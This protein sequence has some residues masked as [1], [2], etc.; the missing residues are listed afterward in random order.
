M[1]S[2]S[3][4]DGQIKGLDQQTLAKETDLYNKLTYKQEQKELNQKKIIEKSNE[5]SSSKFGSNS[6]RLDES[7]TDYKDQ[8]LIPMIEEDVDGIT[9]SNLG[10]NKMA[11]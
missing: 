7:K 3:N 1:T 2:T 4:Q 6:H 5:A 9:G 8:E 10:S 11:G